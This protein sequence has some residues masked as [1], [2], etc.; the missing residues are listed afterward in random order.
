MIRRHGVAVLAGTLVLVVVGLAIGTAVRSPV[1][2]PVLALLGGAPVR[3]ATVRLGPAVLVPPLLV[4]AVTALRASGRLVR[5]AVPWAL[6]AASPIVLFLV[7]RLN[8]VVDAA[9]LI[10]VYATA[11]GG[12]CCG[13]CTAPAATRSP[14][15]GRRSSASSRGAWW[16]SP[17]SAAC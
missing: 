2:L 16:R 3:L 17:R 7:A 12:V 1:G 5:G 8:A 13:P 6:A 9:A 11:A 14:C 4:A 15:A 10:L